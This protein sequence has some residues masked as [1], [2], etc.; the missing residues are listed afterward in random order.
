MLQDLGVDV[1]FVPGVEEIY[2]PGASTSVDVGRLGE[3]LEGAV[4]PGHFRGVATVVTILFDLVQPTRAYFGQKDGQQSVIREASSSR[5][6]WESSERSSADSSVAPSVFT[7]RVNR[8]ASSAHWSARSSCS[9]STGWRPDA[10][11]SRKRARRLKGRGDPSRAT[12]HN[13]AA[14][15]AAG[16][17][18]ARFRYKNRAMNDSKKHPQKSS[19]RRNNER[20]A[21][22]RRAHP[23]FGP[24]TSGDADRRRTER[25]GK[26]K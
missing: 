8:Q 22:K 6:F 19:D 10:A 17:F 16:F 5:S 13:P 23:R 24:A 20:R 7:T 14:T 4:R 15:T 21:D 2:P 9:R 25:R 3:L 26:D 12:K 1:A 11:G 18:F